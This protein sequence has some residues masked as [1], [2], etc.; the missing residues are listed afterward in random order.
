M[1]WTGQ[2]FRKHNKGLTPT[3]SAKAARQANAILKSGGSERIAIAT[4]SKHAHDKPKSRADKLY[5]KRS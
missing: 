1:P 4:A 3:Q 5:G 2:T